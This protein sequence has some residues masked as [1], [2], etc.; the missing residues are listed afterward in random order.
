MALI[1][2]EECGKEISDTAAEC[3]HCGCPIEKKKICQEC[4][5]EVN[6]S[7]KIC[8]NCGAKVKNNFVEDF[9]KK[10]MKSNKIN[11]NQNNKKYTVIGISILVMI[12][13]LFM[14]SNSLKPDIVGTWEW[15]YDR[16]AFGNEVYE[17]Y[18]FEKGNKCSREASLN[19]HDIFDKEIIQSVECKYKFNFWGNKIKIMIYEDGKLQTKDSEWENF[20]KN[21][22]KIYI[23]NR[24]Y[25]SR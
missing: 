12:I 23:D 22:N 2:C 9:I 13:I 5:K 20:E 16:E 11:F 25:T 14:I 17:T 1:K 6:L 8:K 10:F 18:T 24:E 15:Q 7:D 19:K 21:G 4:G 3:I